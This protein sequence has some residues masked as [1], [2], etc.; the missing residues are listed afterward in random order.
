LMQKKDFK[1]KSTKPIIICVFDKSRI[2][3]YI[4]ILNK[5]RA[6]DIS[7]EIYP[8]E[9]KLKKQME[10][11]NKIGSPAVILYGDDEIKSGK[12][13]LKNLETGNESSVKIEDLV[14][15]IKKLL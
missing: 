10:Y 3:E 8:G 9:G 12:V 13:T 15:E 2:K 1:T 6:S 7:S 14:N 11:A 5:L 4:E